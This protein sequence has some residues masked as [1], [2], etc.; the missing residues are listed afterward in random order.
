MKANKIT[1]F[2]W[3]I[4]GSVVFIVALV[5]LGALNKTARSDLSNRELAMICTTDMATEF[6]IHPNISIIADGKT[7]PIPPNIGVRAGCM[8]PLHTHDAD[9]TIHVEAPEKRDFTLADFFAVW[10]EPF[11]EEQVLSYIT[12]E[13]HR[14]RVTAN[15]KEVDD[16]E[17]LVMKDRQ[18][19][20]IFYE[21]IT[22]STAEDSVDES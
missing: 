6:H 20:V 4:I 19:I 10:S 18:E 5:L 17:N 21:E 2:H 11:S 14:I 7:V 15:G 22:T 13:T 16:F 9:G 8:N 3:V 12:D 1:G